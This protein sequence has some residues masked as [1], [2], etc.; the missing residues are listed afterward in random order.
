MS[1]LK[2]RA[3]VSVSA[4][5]L[6]GCASGVAS[7]A[8]MEGEAAVVELEPAVADVLAS[9]PLLTEWDGPY[10]GV[11][12]FS[13]MDLSHVRAA[14]EAGMAA[15]L[16][17]IEAIANDPATPTFENVIVAMQRTGEPLDRAYTCRRRNSARSSAS[18]R[19]NC[20]RI[21]PRSSRTRSCMRGSR[22]STSS[23]RAWT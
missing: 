13:V 11:P 17:E 2:S 23:A 12:D 4:L 20:R 19:R 14:M 8:A 3:I 15:E 7:E 1:I 21:R 10:G 22:R 18:W 9:N 5:V 16:V 6:A